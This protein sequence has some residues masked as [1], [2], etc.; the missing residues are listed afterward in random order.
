MT[1]LTTYIETQSPDLCQYVGQALLRPSSLLIG[2]DFRV[3][4]D[5]RQLP[6]SSFIK[7]TAVAAL[8]IMLLP[9]TLVSLGAGALLLSLSSTHEVAYKKIKQKEITV[10]WKKG[11]PEIHTHQLILRP[12]KAED[13]T[14]YQK[15]FSDQITMAKYAGGPRDITNRFMG[16][17]GRWNEHLFSAFAVID[18]NARKVIGHV[19]S[20]HGDYEGSFT[21]GWSEM[22]IV[23]DK[24]HWNSHFKDEAN[25]IGTANK[26]NIG[27]EIARASIAYA[28]AL[29]E[30]SIPVPCDV[31]VAQRSE[32]E[33]AIANGMNLKVHRNN[34][35]QIDWLYLPFTELRASVANE[36][37]GGRKILEQVF[38]VENQAVRTPKNTER[39]LFVVPL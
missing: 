1:R 14:F 37:T 22:A 25:G 20:G 5:I 16:W 3:E 34:D 18:S 10:L 6:P 33:M 13:L 29:K 9:L 32:I 11:K 8:A 30:L 4:R 2:R 7:R 24:A 39:D 21:K 23:V 27:S 12:I 28:K 31:S 15:I 35:G 38:F 26:Q 19:I 17:L 36:N